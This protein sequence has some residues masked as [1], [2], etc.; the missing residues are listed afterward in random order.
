MRANSHECEEAECF[1]S[2]NGGF[3]SENAVAD[4]DAAA[5][6]SEILDE[7]IDE[8]IE[9]VSKTIHNTDPQLPPDPPPRRNGPYLNV[10]G[11]TR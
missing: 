11:L 7:I 9:S 6:V 10:I 8:I 2:P 3:S 1:R 4:A 5:V